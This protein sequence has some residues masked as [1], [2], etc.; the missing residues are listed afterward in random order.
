[1][2]DYVDSAQKAGVISGD[3]GREYVI[4]AT[5]LIQSDRNQPLIV[6]RRVKFSPMLSEEGQTPFAAAAELL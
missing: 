5:G 1:M 6:G 3:D 2:I 4:F